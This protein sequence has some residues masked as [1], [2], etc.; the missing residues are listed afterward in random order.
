[1]KRSL[2]IILLLALVLRLGWALTRPADET[3]L[4]P[5]P[6]QR[7]YLECARNLLTSGELKFVDPR[8]NDDVRAFRT[9]G[10]PAFVAACGANVRIV[11]VIQTIV[12]TL[13]ALAAFLLAC[14]WL[15]AWGGLLAASLVAVNPFLIYFTGLVLTETLFTAMLAWGMVLLVT[16]NGKWWVLGGLVLCLSIL[17]RPG[18]LGLPIVLALAFA[19]ANRHQPF[20]Y[21]EDANAIVRRWPLPVGATIV[22]L[23]LLVLSPWAFRNYRIIGKW[24]WSST[25]TG[26]SAYDG[27]NPDASGASDQSF[28]KSMP[29]LRGM[30]ESERSEYLSNR[31]WTFVR[32]D[33]RTAT[34]LAVIKL[35]RTWSPQPLSATL[36]RPLYVVIGWLFAG[37][38]YVLVL[39]GICYGTLPRMTKLFLLIPAIYLSIGAMLSVGSLRYRIPAEVPLTVLAAS[40]VVTM[41]HL[42]N[43]HLGWRRAED[44]QGV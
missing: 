15:P 7:E 34:E 31:A 10:Y 12:D 26:F 29:Q 22:L 3:A 27:F 21:H 30:Q 40:A 39:I 20:P 37:P 42:W 5:L 38:I 18:A 24:V 28:V 32:E 8:F 35:A 25:N 43:E 11:R 2:L 33:P 41:S 4:A 36:S 44:A 17:V 1:M 19:L 9:P 16:R 13:T 14:R 6:D 23:S